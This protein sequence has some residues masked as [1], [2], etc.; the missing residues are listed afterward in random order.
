MTPDEDAGDAVAPTC[1]TDSGAADDG[2]T[3]I[4]PE[5]AARL[6]RALDRSPSTVTTLI[7]ATMRTRWVSRSSRWVTGVDPDRR[8]G[9]GSLER[10][11]PDDVERI[12]HALAQLR[13]ARPRRTPGVPVVEPLRYRARDAGGDWYTM[14]S[15]VLNL[16]DDPAVDGLVLVGRRAGGE[17]DGV[18]HVVDLLVADAP[19]PEVLAAC[20]RLVPGSVGAAAVVGLVDGGPVIGAPAGGPAERL[21]R[22]DR[23]WQATVR[24]GDVRGAIDFSGF[25]DD[26]A[27]RARAEGFSS[28]WVLPVSDASSGAVLGCVVVWTRIDVELNMAT[29]HGIRQAQRLA[30]MVIA[31]QRRHEALR[32]EAIT[33]PL[34]G[35]GNRTALQRRLDGAPGPITVALLD[36]DDFK[37]VNDRYGHTA[38]DQVLRI[39]G[40]RLQ[41]SVR[42]LD[43]VVRYGGDEFAVVFGDGTRAGGVGRAVGRITE[44]VE[45]PIRLSSGATISVG[46][47]VGVA[48]GAPTEVV[49]LADAALYRAKKARG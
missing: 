13:A 22:D 18:G 42:Q 41:G 45:T 20:A 16:L 29:D 30:S 40:A 17:L 6:L 31:E 5:V 34:T 33:D 49:R 23:W 9:R 3:D 32:R 27:E 25:P 19:L 12:L 39:V 10:V 28:A 24:D 47:S 35:V 8:A 48:T 26:L 7:D 4:P 38:G 46:V 44:A 21:C 15:L 36:L 11:H 1:D 14:E 2:P 43:L 37:P